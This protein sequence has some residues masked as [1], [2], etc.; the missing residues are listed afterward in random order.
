MSDIDITYKG[1]SIATMNASG[2]KTLLTS[3]KYCEDDIEIDYTKPDVTVDSLTITSGG[4]YTAQT[5]HAYSP[6]TVPSGSASTPAT[7]VTANPSISVSSGGLITA[8]ASATKSVTPS[9]SAGWVSSGT[10]GTITVN[11]SNTSQLST[12]AGKTVTPTESEQ[13]AVAA[14]KYTTGIVKVGAISSTYV[15]SGITQRDDSDLSVSGATVTVPSGYYADNETATVASGSA[16]TPTA[17]KGTVSNHQVS[18]TPSVTNTTGYISGGTINGTAVSVSASELVSGTKSI[19]AN[20]T[21]IDVT[22]YASVDVAVPTG[23]ATL[24]TKNITANGTYNASSDSADGYSSVTVNV[25]GGGGLV[26][27]TGTWTPTT[28]ISGPTISFQNA[29]TEAPVFVMISD[30]TGSYDDTTHTCQSFV[31]GDWE[32]AFGTTINPS[33]SSSQYA[34]YRG[35]YRAS[36]A[37]AYSNTGTIFI[38]RTS[39]EAYVN[40][41]RFVPSIG[42]GYY[43]RTNRTYKWIAVWAPTT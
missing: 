8:T 7:S 31:Y 43:W 39:A 14:G 35:V 10:A 25:S 18:I 40:S 24:I 42:S 38:S 26:Y 4:T 36:N 29:H 2:T 11:G 33:T 20:G 12:E 22:N 28:D 19:S 13:T 21:G 41:S 16:G 32:K 30:A 1:A 5:G 37:T 15:G 9:V 17:S 6:V 34:L 23:S 3:G 27:E